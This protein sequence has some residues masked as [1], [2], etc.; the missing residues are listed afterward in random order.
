MDNQK[1]NEYIKQLEIEIN[2]LPKKDRDNHIMEVKDHLLQSVNDGKSVDQA[3]KDFLPPNELAKEIKAEFQNLYSSAP[4]EKSFPIKQ[5][6]SN[7]RIWI[8]LSVLV[9]IILLSIFVAIAVFMGNSSDKPIDTPG[10][11]EYEEIKD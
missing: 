10:I 8:I 4:I 9:S 11:I 5:K 3:L 6:K 1:I 2:I 7:K